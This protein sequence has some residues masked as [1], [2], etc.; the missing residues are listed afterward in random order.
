MYQQGEAHNV[1]HDESDDDNGIREDDNDDN[2]DNTHYSDVCCTI[3]QDQHLKIN[4]H[5]TLIIDIGSTLDI[6]G[7]KEMVHGI[8]DTTHPL[9]VNEV[10]GSTNISKIAYLGDYP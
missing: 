5:N 9:G 10:D 4:K 3:R 7:D 2:T 8:H 1:D 6:I